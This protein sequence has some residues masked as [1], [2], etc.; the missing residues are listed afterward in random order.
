C[1][2]AFSDDPER[3]CTEL[4]FMKVGDALVGAHKTPS[5]R[6]VSRTAPYMHAGQLPT[7]EAVVEQYDEA[8]N[9][10]IGHNEAMPLGLSARARSDL[11]AFLNSL[12]SPVTAE[13]RWLSPPES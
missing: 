10:M 3:R 5:L 1:L 4:Q 2:G 13:P 6:N 12:D 8:L 11:V 7:L 9:A